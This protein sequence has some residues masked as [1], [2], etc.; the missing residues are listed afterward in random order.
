MLNQK[1][2]QDR[3]QILTESN[4]PNPRKYSILDSMPMSPTDGLRNEIAYPDN[5]SQSNQLYNE[6]EISRPNKL[7]D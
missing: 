4:D 7:K 1:L 5:G 3:P 2:G 6:T